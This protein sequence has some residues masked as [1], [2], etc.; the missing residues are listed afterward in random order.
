MFL[1]IDRWTVSSTGSQGGHNEVGAADEVVLDL[2]PIVRIGTTNIYVATITEE[3]GRIP[4]RTKRLPG[5]EV[6]VIANSSSE[7]VFINGSKILSINS[8]PTSALTYEQVKRRLEQVTW[9]IVLELERP[10]KEEQ[11]PSMDSILSIDEKTIQYNAFKILLAHGMD[12]VKHNK[13]N[14]GFH[15]TTIR[16]SDKEVNMSRSVEG[17]ILL[18]MVVS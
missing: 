3:V 4:F 12:F 17:Y 11:V 15:L 7:T 10:S 16:I 14:R 6:A 13:N 18:F 2:L 8:Y 1:F 5:S 9:P